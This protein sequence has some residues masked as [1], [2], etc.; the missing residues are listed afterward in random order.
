MRLTDV[1]PSEPFAANAIL[2]GHRVVYSAAYLCL[3][4]RLEQY[5]ILICVVNV[6]ELATAEGGVTYCSLIF[7]G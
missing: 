6:S 1:H 5:K 7:D 3:G 2:L 4:K